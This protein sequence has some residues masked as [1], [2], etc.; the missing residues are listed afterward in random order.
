MTLIG[1]GKSKNAYQL[2]NP[3]DTDRKR[4]EQKPLPLINADDTDRKR[5]AI[6]F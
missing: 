5:A 3:D 6:G 4:Q 2:I 1:K